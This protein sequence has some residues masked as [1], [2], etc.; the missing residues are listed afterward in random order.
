VIQRFFIKSTGRRKHKISASRHIRKI[1]SGFVICSTDFPFITRIGE[2]WHKINMDQMGVAE[3]EDLDSFADAYLI[4]GT[5][6][7]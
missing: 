4:T 6:V 3:D 7:F 1:F 5:V 2:I